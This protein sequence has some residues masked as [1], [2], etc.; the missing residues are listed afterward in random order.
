M[1]NKGIYVDGRGKIQARD[2]VVGDGSSIVNYQ[3][4]DSQTLEAKMQEL[5]QLMHVHRAELSN[6]DELIE[7]V[8]LVNSELQKEKPNKITVKSIWD[9][10]RSSVSFL[11]DAAAVA[12]SMQP[13]ITTVLNK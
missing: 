5:I 11:K 1:Q 2:I 13:L 7:S 6:P 10:I 9:T 8:E 12:A 3:S 4:S